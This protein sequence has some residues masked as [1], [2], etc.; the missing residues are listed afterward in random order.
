MEISMG[1]EHYLQ[2]RKKSV[3]RCA[4]LFNP[5]LDVCIGSSEAY[6]NGRYLLLEAIFE[7]TVLF[8]NIYSPNDNN[9]QNTFFTQLS[10]SLR[11]HADMQIVMGGDFNC[12]LAPLD[13]TA[14]TSTERKKIVMNKI[15]NLCTNYDLQDVWRSQHSRTSQYTWRNNSLKVQCRLDYWLVSK[16]L[17]FY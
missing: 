10:D 1:R 15:K 3:K 14:G 17:N 9:S 12:A 11:R 5:K 8:C 6:K 16:E 7:S 13:K 4:I 2:S